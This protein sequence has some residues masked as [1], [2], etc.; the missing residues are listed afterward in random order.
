MVILENLDSYLT[1]G[2]IGNLINFELMKNEDKFGSWDIGETKVCRVGGATTLEDNAHGWEGL[3][4]MCTIISST[5]CTPMQ[6]IRVSKLN[7][8]SNNFSPGH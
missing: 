3:W 6:H 7:K 2:R 4:Q 8:I 5:N 1:G